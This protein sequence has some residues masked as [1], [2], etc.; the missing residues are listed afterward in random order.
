MHILLLHSNKL[1]KKKS[2]TF[3]AYNVLELFCI[4]WE[5]PKL[6]QQK[7]QQHSLEHKQKLYKVSK[8]R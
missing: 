4:P 1:K 6:Q 2:K 5:N 3:L 8:A 7:A